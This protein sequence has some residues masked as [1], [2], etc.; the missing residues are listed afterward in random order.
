MILACF[1]TFSKPK[2]RKENIWVVLQDR[3]DDIDIEEEREN[4]LCYR[5]KEQFYLEMTSE[6]V[7]SKEFAQFSFVVGVAVTRIL[8]F[9]LNDDV[10]GE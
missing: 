4:D 3:N 6:C 2:K 10:S 7:G 8:Q 9:A 5:S 1:Y